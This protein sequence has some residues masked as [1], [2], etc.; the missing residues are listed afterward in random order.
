VTVRLTPAKPL[1][2]PPKSGWFYPVDGQ[3]GSR[4]MVYQQ[5]WLFPY[6]LLRAS[7]AA[8]IACNV[9]TGG[10]AGSTIRLGVYNS[11]GAGGVGGLLVDA[12]TVDGS[13]T[14]VKTVS[15][16]TSATAADRLWLG[17]VWQG[18]NTTAPVLQAYSKALAGVGWSSFVQFPPIIGWTWTGISGALPATLGAPAGMENNNTPSVQITFA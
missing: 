3:G 4:T 6:D 17:A 12:G 16:L 15:S 10:T 14:G 7:T 9:T 18:V 11:D 13:T 2:V 8:S 1:V 5:L